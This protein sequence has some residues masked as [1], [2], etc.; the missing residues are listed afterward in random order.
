MRRQS[1]FGATVV[2]ILALAACSSGGND[3]DAASGAAIAD[4]EAA[5][6]APAEDAPADA[7]KGADDGAG[8][9]ADEGAA[10]AIIAPA[11]RST[12]QRQII[13]TVDLSISTDDV[14]GAAQRAATIAISAGGLVADEHTSGED[15][16]TLTL[17]VP[18][19][20]HQDTIA[21]LE[22]L[23][24]VTDRSRGTQDVTDEVVDT[25]SRIVSQRAS[26][27]RI[28]ALLDDATDLSD[29]ISIES[30]LAGREA[31]LDALLSRQEQLAGLTS[32]A[33]VTVS[34]YAYGEEPPPDDDRG[35]LAGLGGG[36]DAFV[37][38]GALA[39][40]ILGAVLPFAA[41]A[42]LVGMPGYVL[43]RRRRA[44]PAAPTA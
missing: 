20:D 15:S 23:G 44:H 9:S 8:E 40:T 4:E 21:K 14:A 18:A 17:R 36:W 19:S 5:A 29:V 32:M 30:E 11:A 16:S 41:L 24:K 38:A 12:T 22:E 33:T 39:L 10:S 28:R 37:A 3:T 25:A 31:D 2:A 13:Y 6:P 7:D 26:I 42:A 35:F 1:A 43:I 27:A 34:L